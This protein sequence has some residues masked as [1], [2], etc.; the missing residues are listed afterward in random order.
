MG[1]A[2][3]NWYLPTIG[4]STDSWGEELND[5]LDSQDSLVRRMINNF[6]NSSAPAEAQAGT[7]WLDNTTNPY[8]LKIY[9][10]TD[11]ISMGTLNTSTNTFDVA[12]VSG[13]VGDMKFSA[14]TTNH[15][16]WLLCNGGAVSTS[17]YSSLFALIGYSFGGSGATFN[18]PDLR[19]RVA[20]AIGSGSGLTTRT[21]GE[22]VGEEEHTLTEAEM[23][24]HTHDWG[25]DTGS[26]GG[27]TSSLNSG[28]TQSQ[29]PTSSTG[30]GDAFNIMQPTLFVGSYFIF[31]GV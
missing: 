20:G 14:Q 16:G 31:S 30:G 3:F 12:T 22:T 17:I 7:M 10:G 9:D 23:P 25:G 11:W 26:I 5:N 1:T 28:G 21:L 29:S 19:G 27:A 6:I 24:A 4:G 8:N 18:L 15:G 13:Y 2:N